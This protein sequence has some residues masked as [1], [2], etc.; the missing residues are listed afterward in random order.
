MPKPSS[1]DPK[2]AED[3]LQRLAEGELLREM[4]RQDNMPSRSS[5]NDWILKDIN[6]FAGQYARARE[7]GMHAI[8][9][10]TLSLSDNAS[11][12]WMETNDPDNPGWRVNGDHIQRSRLRVDT[13]KW[14]ASKILPKIYGD[15]LDL[16]H[17]GVLNVKAM[18]DDELDARIARL[19]V[20]VGLIGPPR[21]EGDAPDEAPAI[22]GPSPR[23]D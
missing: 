5:V 2:I 21:G 3:I 8:V 20:Q 10:E 16:N 9:E 4:C 6:G 17:T 15:K 7:T 18:P 12:D 22:A 11:N 19:T 13:R 14:L 1:Y 23:P